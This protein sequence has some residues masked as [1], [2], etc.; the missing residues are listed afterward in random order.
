MMERM[1]VAELVLLAH[2]NHILVVL[3]IYM[4]HCHQVGRS[5]NLLYRHQTKFLLGK[6][7]TLLDLARPFGISEI[8]QSLNNGRKTHGFQVGL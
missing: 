8:P 5:Q 3:S 7:E 2:D 6:D 4:L 1:L